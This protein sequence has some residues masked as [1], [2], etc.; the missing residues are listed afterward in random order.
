MIETE[1][2]NKFLFMC[3]IFR[4]LASDIQTDVW[5]DQHMEI[6]KIVLDIYLP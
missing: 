2:E 6:V 3:D 5:I 1:K 4:E